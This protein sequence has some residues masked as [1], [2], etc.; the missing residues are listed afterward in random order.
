MKMSIRQK[1]AIFYHE[2]ERKLHKLEA[3]GLLEEYRAFNKGK[4]NH[5]IGV[6]CRHKGITL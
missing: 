1:R 4:R 6:F 2:R 5:T 3:L